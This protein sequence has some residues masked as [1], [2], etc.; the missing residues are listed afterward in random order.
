M[1][2]QSLFYKDKSMALSHWYHILT[3]SVVGMI[4]HFL[5]STYLK[6]VDVKNV[7]SIVL[8]FVL[9]FFQ[10]WGLDILQ[11]DF[12]IHSVFNMLRLCVGAWMCLTASAS[13]KMYL[14]KSWNRREFLIEHGGEF[15]GII[16]IGLL[17][18]ALT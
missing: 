5:W 17:I 14:N 8:L 6:K 12:E 3:A 2:N 16:L 13:F 11:A 4:F 15:V 1:N 9:S 18:F 10:A 7:K